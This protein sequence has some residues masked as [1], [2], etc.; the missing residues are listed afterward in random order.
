MYLRC[1]LFDLNHLVFY[2][3]FII[4]IIIKISYYPWIIEGEEK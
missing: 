1:C 3:D 4:T 2:T